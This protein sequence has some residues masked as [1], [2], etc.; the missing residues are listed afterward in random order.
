MDF[1]KI[2]KQVV[3][4]E[5]EEMKNVEKSID[6]NFVKA[7][8]LI[9]KCKGKI[10]IS[11]IG[12]SGLIGKKISANFAS[13]GKPSFFI[14]P[15]EALHG[16]MGNIE[17][18]DILIA[19]SCSGNT[20]ELQDIVLYCQKHKVKTIAITCNNN[21]FLT[22]SCDI[23]IV[24]SMKKEAIDGFPVPT[25]SSLMTLAICDAIT[26]C[27]VKHSKLTREKYGEFHSG[28]SIGASIRKKK[29]K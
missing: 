8:T 9:T 7:T 14:H 27:I 1:I 10:L 3:N 2:A 22:K 21:S 20:K 28:G 18:N 29:Q 23:S 12:K 19:L 13:V 11:G 26:A 17:K 16:D 25:S 4:N 15:V 24:L 5:I 6:E